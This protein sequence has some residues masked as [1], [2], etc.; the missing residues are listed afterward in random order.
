MATIQSALSGIALPAS[1]SQAQ[2]PSLRYVGFLLVLACG[3]HWLLC[4]LQVV[5]IHANAGLVG[6]VEFLIYLGCVPLF[7]HRISVRIVSALL[8]VFGLLTLLAIL[9]GGFVDIK[10]MRDL[11]I[12]A[13]FLWVGRS[14]RG[15]TMDLDRIVRTLVLIVIA[16]GLV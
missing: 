10:A 12:P 13:L 7:Y 11:L 5:G 3:H 9:R 4:A 14:W 15:S 6:A 1:Q 2:S 16:I 8:L